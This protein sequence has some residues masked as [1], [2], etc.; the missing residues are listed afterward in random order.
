MEGLMKRLDIKLTIHTIPPPINAPLHSYIETPKEISLASQKVKELIKREKRPS[1][2]I[3]RGIVN[4]VS[5]GTKTALTNP[6]MIPNKMVSLRLSI[7][8]PG[9]YL[10]E[11]TT[12]SVVINRRK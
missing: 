4:N 7:E 6:N 1:V 11:S 12:V 8:S 5:I 10:A 9:T 2:R 3:L